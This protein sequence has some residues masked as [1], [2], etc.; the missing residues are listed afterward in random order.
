VPPISKSV[1]NELLGVRGLATRQVR[2]LL[3]SSERSNTPATHI[4]CCPREHD[5]PVLVA[6]G[7]LIPLGDPAANAPKWFAAVEVIGLVVDRDWL[8]KATK[9][10]SKHWRDKRER[11]MSTSYSSVV[12]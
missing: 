7:K 1:P 3:Y 9:E 11:L 4:Q 6:A 8:H 12:S 10:I 2:R 5:I